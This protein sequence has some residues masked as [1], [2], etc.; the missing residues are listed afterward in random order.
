MLA[1]VAAMLVQLS[2]EE[3]ARLH[4]DLAPPAGETWRSIPWKLA[5]LEARDAAAREKKP[6][7]VWSMNGHPLGCV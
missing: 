3:F 1:L 7:F 5:M 2:D 4:Q 6:A